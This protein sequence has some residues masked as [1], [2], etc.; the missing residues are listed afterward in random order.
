M[1]VKAELAYAFYEPKSLKESRGRKGL[2]PTAKDA[3]SKATWTNYEI[4]KKRKKR[5][6]FLMLGSALS[7]SKLTSDWW[8]LLVDQCDVYEKFQL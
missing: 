7:V 6:A 8:D 4:L 1:L 3:Y 5:E 2:P